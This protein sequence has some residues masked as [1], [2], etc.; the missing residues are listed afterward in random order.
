MDTRFHD[1]V[2]QSISVC[3]VR[4]RQ[5]GHEPVKMVDVY[6]VDASS[7]VDKDCAQM[8][9]TRCDRLWVTGAC[10]DL[11]CDLQAFFVCK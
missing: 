9:C 2:T 5:L 8:V 4:C 1:E 10:F 6:G 7:R 3:N 11:A